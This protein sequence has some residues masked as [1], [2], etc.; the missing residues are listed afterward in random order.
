MMC[1]GVIGPVPVPKEVTQICREMWE[2]GG[3]VV[4]TKRGWRLLEVWKVSP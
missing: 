1:D 2:I 4:K 3:V